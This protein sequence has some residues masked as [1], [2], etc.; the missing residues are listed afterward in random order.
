MSGG[1][2]QGYGKKIYISVREVKYI[3][4]RVI[5]E[6]KLENCHKNQRLS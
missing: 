1:R 6:Q 4:Y 5:R 3:I 2:I